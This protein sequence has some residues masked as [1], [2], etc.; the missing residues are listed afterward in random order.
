MYG[1]L[2]VDYLPSLCGS[3]VYRSVYVDLMLREEEGTII[4]CIV[5]GN[6]LY[7]IKDILMEQVA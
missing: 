3:V 4:S 1:P 2:I 6:I 5:D 7:E